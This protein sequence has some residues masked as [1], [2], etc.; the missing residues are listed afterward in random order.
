MD[1]SI[2]PPPVASPQ[3]KTSGYAIASLVSSIIGVSPVGII[4]GHIA[5]SK[6]R[7]SGGQLSGYGL[8]LAGTIIGY[9]SF[10]VLIVLTM[11][12]IL[13]VGARA[14]KKGSDRAACTM[15]RNNI[16][17]MVVAYSQLNDIEVGTS[18]DLDQIKLE[19]DMKPMGID[20]P[21]DGEMDVSP[22]YLGPQKPH[23]TC[24]SPDHMP[25]E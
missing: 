11:I 7:K 16:D 6:I 21:A 15:T 25:L 13:F 22:I 14:W 24:S 1:T 9:I 17:Q 3:A 23:A 10:T 5:L 8:A 4:C 19:F 20:C 2:T 18:I 12:S